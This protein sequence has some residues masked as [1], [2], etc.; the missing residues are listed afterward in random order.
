MSN[1]IE[2]PSSIV[3]GYLWTVS[4]RK[5]I[6][7]IE[8][9][10]NNPVYRKRYTEEAYNS[11]SQELSRQIEVESTKLD[12]LAIW[13]DRERKKL[14]IEPY[15]LPG[16]VMDFAN[17]YVSLLL[18][19]AATLKYVDSPY[20]EKDEELFA[21]MESAVDSVRSLIEPKKK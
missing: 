3:E 15:K 9:E 10:L 8:K 1:S 7:K 14:A 17:Q 12:I 16:S 20:E 21:E 4:L 18:V 5:E 2:L 11:W 13:V 19:A 6:A